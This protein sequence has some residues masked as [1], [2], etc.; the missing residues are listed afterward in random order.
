MEQPAPFLPMRPVIF[1]PERNPFAMFSPSVPSTRSADRPAT[2]RLQASVPALLIMLAALHTTAS[3]QVDYPPQPQPPQSPQAAVTADPPGRVAWLGLAEGTVSFAPN[4]TDASNDWQPAI[5]N[6]PL[7][8]GERLWTSPRSRAELHVGSTA[9]RM[10]ESTSLDFFALDD[11]QTQLRVVQG[12]VQLRVRTLFDGQRL[13]INTPNLA[14]VVTQPGTYRLDVNPASNTTRVVALAGGALLYGDND[15]PLTLEGA[16]QGTFTGTSLIPAAPGAAVQD[17]FDQWSAGR[18]R[19]EEHSVS[20]RYVP[21]ETVGYQQLDNYGD[22]QRDPA[23]GPVWIPRAVPENWAP[24]RAGQ[25]SWVAPWGWTW[26]DEAPW[27]F[28]PFH[29]G[30]WAQIGPRWAWVPGRLPQRPVYAPALVGFV[31]SSHAERPVGWFP[32]APGEAFRPNYRA[33]ERHMSQLNY[34]M[35]NRAQFNPTQGYSYQNQNNAVSAM[36]RDDF[37]HGRPVHNHLQSLSANELSQPQTGSNFLMPRPSRDHQRDRDRNDL[38]GVNRLA[39]AAL[40]PASMNAQP[41]IVRGHDG[42]GRPS[43]PS[44]QSSQP[45]RGANQSNAPQRQ[46][47]ESR[48]GW[49]DRTDRTDHGERTDRTD[50]TN[51]TNRSG[52]PS[53]P[54]GSTQVQPAPAT[55]ASATGGTAP[56]NRQPPGNHQAQ[57]STQPPASTP[58]QDANSAPHQPRGGRNNPAPVQ[59]LQPVQPGQPGQ[60]V[61]PVQPG[62]AAQPVQPPPLRFI[63]VAQPS[64]PPSANPAQ[65]PQQQPQRPARPDR[66]DRQDPSTPHQWPGQSSSPAR[67]A[68]AAVTTPGTHRPSNAQTPGADTTPPAAQPTRPARAPIERPAPEQLQRPQPPVQQPAQPDTQRQAEQLRRQSDEQQAQRAQ[69]EQA[70]RTQREQA[71]KAAQEQAQRAAA[72]AAQTTRTAAPPHQPTPADHPR[73]HKPEDDPKN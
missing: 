15:A 32:L 38:R 59:P 12:T 27:G 19:A 21:R 10:D 61:Q 13:E 70:L 9:V 50:R 4:D 3:A 17:H 44:S 29:Y 66:P 47:G 62:Q 45:E 49:P 8:E 58:A 67:P 14:F 68:D 5:L 35:G 40:P 54:D 30:R 39:P 7:V 48:P 53:R 69:R 22:W 16:Q 42:R 52:N 57:P 63:P 43:G 2:R 18:D 31:G 25:W 55:P 33:S 23:Y 6:R 36:S 37:M 11:N 64:Q 41:V 24:Y 20:A 1:F 71:Q 72:A 73:Q 26:V 60:P 56:W 65:T 34:N 51:R 28:A 46:P